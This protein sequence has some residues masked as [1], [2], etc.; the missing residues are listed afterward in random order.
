MIRSLVK[1]MGIAVLVSSLAMPLASAAVTTGASCKKLGQ[2]STVAGKKYVCVK[3]GKKSVWNQL[4]TIVNPPALSP[5]PVNDLAGLLTVM[6]KDGSLWFDLLMKRRIDGSYFLADGVQ[7]K[8]SFSVNFNLQDIWE[9]SILGCHYGGECVNDTYVSPI[10][11]GTV[12]SISAFEKVQHPD[13]FSYGIIKEAD[14]GSSS[15]SVIAHLS[16]IFDGLRSVIYR[17]DLATRTKIPI[18]AT[19]VNANLGGDIQSLR[20]DHRNA[21]AYFVLQTG[22]LGL[23]SESKIVRISTES[24]GI[25]LRSKQTGAGTQIYEGSGMTPIY[26]EL[27]P[28]KELSNIQLSPK[29]NYLFF[30]R[31]KLTASD[32]EGEICRTNLAAT[33]QTICAQV[34]PFEFLSTL[35]PLDDNSIF[36]ETWDIAADTFRFRVY[37]FDTQITND[38]AGMDK[39]T[40]I[41]DFS[42]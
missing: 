37:S 3:A 42:N 32:R 27:D 8:T 21:E 23:N 15:E 31:S 16:Y 33:F 5:A 39:Y 26:S 38:V 7:Q 30:K 6:S 34:A 4:K 11:G 9:G 20:V 13:F 19:Y 29:G 41:Q 17:Y 35:V 22:N 28:N 1:A 10:G 25:A 24:S 18:F 12:S 2:I 40:W 14:F 36:F